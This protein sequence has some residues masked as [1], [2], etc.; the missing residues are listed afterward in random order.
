MPLDIDE[1]T[2]GVHNC[3]QNQQC[4]NRPGSFICECASGYEPS[5]GG[6]KT[7]DS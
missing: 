2:T 5:N 6:S 1:C 4:V 3:T 7:T